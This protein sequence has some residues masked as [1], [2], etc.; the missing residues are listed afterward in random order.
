MLKGPKLQAWAVILAAGESRR[1]GGIK[2]L[3]PIGGGTALAAVADSARAGGATGV[4]VVT[5]YHRQAVRPEVLACAAVEAHNPEPERGM[6]SSVR[7]GVAAVP[8]AIAILLWP[9]DHPFVRPATVRALLEAALARSDGTTHPI[10]VPTLQGRGGHPTLFPADLRASLLDLDDAGGPNRLL[11]QQAD[12]VLRLPVPDP[13]VVADID[14]PD[15]L[16]PGLEPP[17]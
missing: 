2:A 9:V 4:V 16:P 14:T 12:R 7:A 8:E 5:G 15:D 11:R 6:M 17:R 10:V 13:G 1:F 3:A